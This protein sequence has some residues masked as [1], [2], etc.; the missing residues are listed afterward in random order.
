MQPVNVALAEGQVTILNSGPAPGAK[1]VVDG[2]DRLRPGQPV[3]VSAAHHQLPAAAHGAG[4]GQPAAGLNDQKSPA[5]PTNS[6]P[7][8]YQNPSSNQRQHQ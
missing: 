6:N 4:S 3:S 1:I 5:Q 2:A 7:G 8:K